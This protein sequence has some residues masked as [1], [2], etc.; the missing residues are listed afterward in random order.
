MVMISVGH[1]GEG[2]F[3]DGAG[4]RSFGFPGGDSDDVSSSG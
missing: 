4:N 3:L 2:H 1:L